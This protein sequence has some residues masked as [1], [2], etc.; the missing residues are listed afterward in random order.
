MREESDGKGE[1][2]MKLESLKPVQ[3]KHSNLSGNSATLG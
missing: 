2:E 1:S 3:D